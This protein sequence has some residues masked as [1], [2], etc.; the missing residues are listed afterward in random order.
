M[1]RTT[2]ILA[3]AD[4]NKPRRFEIQAYDG[5]PLSVD[6]FDAPV[7]VDLSTLEI[8]ASIPIV[9]D[10]E[11]TTE[12]TIGSTDVITN[13]GQ[14]L[15]MAGPVTATAER[16]LRVIEQHDK[17]QKW[18][19]SIG[20]Y[21][22]GAQKIAAGEKVT[23]NGREFRGP[24]IIARES[25]LL[26]TG[27]LPSG[28]DYTTQVNLAASAASFLKGAAMPSFEEW[29]AM[30]GIDPAALDE[31]T[32]AALTLAYDALQNPAPAPPVEPPAPAPVAAMPTPPTEEEEEPMAAQTVTAQAQADLT[33]A[34]RKT[35]ADIIRQGAEIQAKAT[36]YP[37]IAA[38]AIE[39]DW[40]IDKVELEVLKAT[41]LKTRPTSF[42]GAQNAP[43][44]MP[45]VLE[46]AMSITR[47]HGNNGRTAK[48]VEIEDQYDDKTLQAAH[49]QF[50]HG[51]G[52]QELFLL[53]AAQNGMPHSAGTRITPGNIR[54]VLEFATGRQL[55]AAFSPL[56]LPGI[57]SNVANKEILDGYIE[58]DA[59][60]REVAQIK[61]VP[62]FK[63]ITS[64]RML[65]NMK[66]EE[67]GAGGVIKHGD[68]D[69]ESYTRQA[70]TYAKMFSLTRTNIIND[71]MSAFDDLKNRIGRGSA[72]K[73]NDLFW[74]TWLGNT[75]TIWTSGRTN[76]ITG[77]TTNLGTDGV[78]LGLGQKAWR[79]RTSPA[80]DG[81]KRVGGRP[82][83]LLVPPEL[84]VIADQLYV[85]RNVDSVA[86]SSAN[87]FAGKYQ[88]IVA[89]Q[90]SDSSYTGYS[91][92]AWWL[93]GD[94][95]MGSPVCV[96]F[97]NGQ[98]T[99]TVETAD[100]DFNTL[101][102]Q[103]RGY[104]DFGCDI[105]EYLNSVMSKGAA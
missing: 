47:G 62:D 75:G 71:D 33:A 81:A 11:T 1:T 70:D 90:L 73:L 40:S 80:V 7:I 39:E 85:A 57:L 89:E 41:S 87:V 95:G 101:G 84:E 105:A 83:Y 72:I 56:S 68:V 32:V 8:P 36:G 20:V 74:T 27:V 54:Q 4:G 97:L 12:T 22:T 43:E 23:V 25:V 82:K 5:G 34:L 28:A 88:P 91:T 76:Y 65:D 3:A 49:T 15:V 24:L 26:H 78:G 93:L 31:N 37:L 99:P 60:W 77:S 21:V 100:T 69:E 52:L 30:L 79:T 53:A 96:S 17:G 14:S 61:S 103:F 94:K 104:H 64:Y 102:V 2:F 67:L 63:T 55:D 19:A 66:Y 48:R 59:A 98:E 45:K 46:A 51:I 58:E 9:C 86:V 6:G 92:T 38:K 13:N 16:P 42:T 18:Q 10:H 50:R 44:N 29:I 35:Q